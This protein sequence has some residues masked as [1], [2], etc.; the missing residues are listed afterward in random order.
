[1]R[2]STFSHAT[3]RCAFTRFCFHFVELHLTLN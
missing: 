3:F 2:T 1:L